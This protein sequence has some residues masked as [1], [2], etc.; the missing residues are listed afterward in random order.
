MNFFELR[1]ANLFR[2]HKTDG[3]DTLLVSHPTNIRYLT[4]FTGSSAFVLLTPKSCLLL[5]DGRYEQQLAEEC[6]GLDVHIR[7]HNVLQ[8]DDLAGIV[9]KYGSKPIGIEAGQMTVATLDQLKQKAPKTTF[10]PTQ[11]K[12]EALRAKKDA[13]EVQAIRGAIA[14]AEK[15]FRMFLAMIKAGSTEIEMHNSMDHYL[16]LAGAK[17]SAFDPIVAFGERGALPHA[18]PT[19]RPLSEATKLLVDWGADC[20]YRSDITRSLKSPFASS[21]SRKNRKERVGYDFDAIYEAVLAAHHAA[22]A[23]LRVGALV[24]DVDTAARKAMSKLSPRD[25]DLSTTFNHGLGHGIGLETHEGPFLRQSTE[26]TLEAGNVVTIEPGAYIPGWGG[27]RIED[28]YLI[29]K[30]GP[31]RLTTLPHDPSALS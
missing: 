19:N 7:P 17:K 26:A 8:I 18:Q 12:V 21:P 11:G 4:G 23:E 15:A 5:S 25:L 13:S 9:T 14:V 27:I 28:D 10:V 20:G 24:K 29:T 31:V 6:P 3:Y 2:N 16:R 30:D 22:V 1:R